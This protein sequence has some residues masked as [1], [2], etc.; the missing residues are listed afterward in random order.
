ML[1]GTVDYNR[2]PL[3]PPGTKIL[4]HEKP[5]QRR[6]WDPHGVEGWYLRPATDH[7]RCYRVY[8]NRTRAE[9]ITDTV[10][11]F[12]QEIEMPFPTPTEV[13]IEA[14]KALI[15]TLNDPIPTMPFAHQQYDRK[16]LRESRAPDSR[17]RTRRSGTH[18]K[19][20]TNQ[21]G[22]APYITEGG[23]PITTT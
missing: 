13:A 15:H 5:N 7:Y 20:H 3:A 2:T 18:Q 10:E 6:S 4:I 21:S 9:R 19:R 8:V 1:N 22:P 14:A 16:T 17:H 11:F 23:N 12:P